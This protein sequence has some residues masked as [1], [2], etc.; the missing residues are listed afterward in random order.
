M[1]D[2]CVMGMVEG[3]FAVKAALLLGVEA[4]LLLS[5]NID[6]KGCSTV[7]TSVQ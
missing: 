2:Q 7:F 5:N 4:A 3:D 6:S 1:Y